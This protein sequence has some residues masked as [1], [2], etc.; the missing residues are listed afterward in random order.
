LRAIAEVKDAQTSLKTNVFKTN[1]QP[2]QIDGVFGEQTARATKRAKYWLGYALKDITGKY[3]PLLDSYLEGRQK[4]PL[5]KRVR[6]NQRVKAGAS[7]PIRQKA[8]NQAKPHIGYKENPPGSNRNKFGDWYGM[9]GVPWC[10]EFVTWCYEQVGSK[11][12]A[13]GHRYAYVPFVVADGRRGINYLAITHQP[14]PGDLVCFDWDNDGVADHIGMVL[15]MGTKGRF[16]TVEG[17]TAV[18]NDSNG[19]EVMQRDRNVRDVQAFVHVAK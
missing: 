4:L 15:E 18:G 10:A 13:R 8:L 11:A 2:G 7:T 14:K 17:N 19:G 5:A 9:D 3:G 12:F 6:R 1:F 16:T